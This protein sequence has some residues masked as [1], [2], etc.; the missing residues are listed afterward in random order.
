MKICKVC[1][2]EF[3]NTQGRSLLCSQSCSVKNTSRIKRDYYERN[4]QEVIDAAT[5]FRLANPSKYK[6]SQ[7]KTRFKD[8]EKTKKDS[9]DYYYKNRTILLKRQQLAS[10]TDHRKQYMKDYAN[11]PEKKE[12]LKA[13]R[14]KYKTR[15]P[16]IAKKGHLKRKFGLSLEDYERM[17]SEQ[18]GACKICR[19][20]ETRMNNK[21]N[22]IAT[23]AVDHC[24]KTGAIRGLLCF[25]CNAAIGML[26]DCVKTLQAAIDYLNV[27]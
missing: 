16:I 24:H 25:K 8:V 15:N 3:K 5:R 9:R 18:D 23:L 1:K 10:K 19:K 2:I 20:I 21:K 22:T 26:S 4:K 11:N 14:F 12:A 7:R 13:D 27:N 6:E 17:L